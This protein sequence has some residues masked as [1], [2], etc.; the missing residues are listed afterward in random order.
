MHFIEG[1]VALRS[2]VQNVRRGRREIEQGT[3]RAASA[4]ARA[5]LEHLS[6]QDKDG[7]DCRCFE[8][9]TDAA[10]LLE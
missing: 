7:N 4:A 6:K 8:I 1:D 3:D 5:Q 9:N 2:V 10:V